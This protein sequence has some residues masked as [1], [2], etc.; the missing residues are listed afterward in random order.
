MWVFT[1]H[2]FKLLSMFE[3][4]ENKMVGKIWCFP[5]FCHSYL[6]PSPNSDF[7]SRVRS[8]LQTHLSVSWASL[9]STPDQPGWRPTS[10][11]RFFPLPAPHLPHPELSFLP[12]LLPALS[13][14]YEDNCNTLSPVRNLTV[15]HSLRCSPNSSVQGPSWSPTLP[16]QGHIRLPCNT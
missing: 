12:F 4:F 10:L 3:I 8:E 2:F 5:G 15:P 13:N 1:V 7:H 6:V 9:P 14:S 11:F 16:L